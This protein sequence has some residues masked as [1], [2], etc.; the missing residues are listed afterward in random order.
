MHVTM[1]VLNR[2]QEM[3]KE[4]V[5]PMTEHGNKAFH[6]SKMYQERVFYID[7]LKGED[8]NSG[9]APE[10][11][12]RSLEKVNE[13][14][15]C[16]GD[17]IRFCRGG[18]W[19][20]M[21]APKGNGSVWAPIVVESYGEGEAP[22][23]HGDGSYA[24]I[25]L[26]GVS[27]WEIK[28]LAVTNQAEDRGVRQGICIC[29]SPQG[30]TGNLVIEGCEISRVTGENRRARDVYQSMYWN[31]GIY[32]TMPGRS[33]DKNHLHNIIISNNYVHDVLTSGIRVNQQED[34]IN[35]IHH[36]HVVV[37]GNRI[38][39]TG[40]DGIIVANCISP[41]ID[42][43]V[44]LDAGALGS[45]EDTRL[46]A[47]IWVCATS[48]ALIQRN[49][50]GGTRL[51]END[52]TAFDTD[53]GTAGDT[54]FQYNYTHDNQGGFWLDCM[55]IN[56]NREC[57]KTILRY[58][59]SIDDKRCLIQ[60]DYGLPAHLY[61]NL[62]FNSKEGPLICCH[63]EGESHM[64]RNNIFC[65]A[66]KPAAGWQKSSF[67]NNWYS[68]KTGFPENDKEASGDIPVSLSGLIDKKPSSRAGCE[69]YWNF[70]ASLVEA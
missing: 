56:R 4:S 51:F 16:P 31:S 30:I 38:E 27:C 8:T 53:W 54:V 36:T 55:G 48:D 20:G 43:N 45:L 58:N 7:C 26:E 44:C 68:D 25:L 62:F 14:I 70:L 61:G 65:F 40:S 2:Y 13:Q 67:Q 21:L 6:E 28:G 60:D 47:G 24:A 46:I 22:V 52:G 19:H 5:I 33:S 63:K 59:I 23:I 66:D 64:F 50:V 12:W 35:D 3:K 1:N 15:F 37:R 39:R 42:E 34:F 41:L 29:A 57:G 49:E 17:R 18:E 69:N 9:F 32:V 10:K 11:A